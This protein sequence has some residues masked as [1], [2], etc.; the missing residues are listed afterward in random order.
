MIY[1][2]L[3]D[4][5]TGIAG[6]ML[7][8]SLAWM[9]KEKK[10]K[11]E[12]SNL[13]NKFNDAAKSLGF[14]IQ[15]SDKKDGYLVSTTSSRE[16]MSFET[17]KNILQELSTTLE[18]NSAYRDL[19]YQA[20]NNLFRAEKYSHRHMFRTEYEEG[21]EQHMHLHEAHDAIIDVLF[22]AILLEKLRVDLQRVFVLKPIPLGKGM[23][24]FSHGTL[25]VPVPAVQYL[26]KGIE[27]MFKQG[28]FR[29]E[30]T[31]PTG[32]AILLALSPTPLK[33]SQQRRIGKKI[34]KGK[35]Y[36]H[37]KLKVENA[38]IAHLVKSKD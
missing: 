19:A 36:G 21:P 34:L 38:L 25:K 33:R 9:L 27:D 16:Q 3:L 2:L 17:L 37:K 11:K 32:L 29:T 8:G 5:K 15:L 6:D 1:G 35:G 4:P 24:K 30:L 18:I 26:L 14:Q 28:N 7:I 31:T 12:L 20:I 22:T 13:T 10:G 23:I